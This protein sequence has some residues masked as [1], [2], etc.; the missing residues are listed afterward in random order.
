MESTLCAGVHLIGIQ[1]PSHALAECA[2]V[3]LARPDTFAR[4]DRHLDPVPASLYAGIVWFERGNPGLKEF[5][6]API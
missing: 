3:F 6:V 1:P 2:Q 4:E 5:S